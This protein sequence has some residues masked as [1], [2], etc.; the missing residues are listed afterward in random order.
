MLDEVD[1]HVGGHEL[2]GSGLLVHLVLQ[3]LQLGRLS[4]LDVLQ[5]GAAWKTAVMLRY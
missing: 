3:Q 4:R 1:G 2:G 5:F